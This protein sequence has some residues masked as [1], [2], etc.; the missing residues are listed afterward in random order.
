[1]SLVGGTVGKV[2]AV[3]LAG[4]VVSA[5]GVG[6]AL[7]TG[8]VSLEPPTV[9]SVENE[10]GEVTDERTGIDTHVAVNNPNGV[11][12]PGVASVSYDVAMNDVT[13]ASG[14]S[15][16]LSLSPGTNEVTLQTHIDN[17]K[18]P[19]WWATHVNNGEQTTVSVQP[20]IDAAFV[21]KSLPSQDRT[22]ET[23]ILSSFNSDESRSMEVGGRTLLTV[24]QTRASW[25]EATEE[26][27]P[28][29]FSGT[30]S[31]PNDAPIVFSKIGYAVTMNDVT[32]AEGT[33]DE[34]VHIG[35]GAT[36]TIHVN[37]TFD[38]GKLDEWW[39][40]HLRNDENT[41]LDVQMF[42][43]VETD[44]G[45]QRVPLPFLSER[46]IFETD[47]LGGGEATTREAEADDAAFEPPTVESI[48]RDWRSTD[49][50]TQFSTQV[51]V[52][53]PNSADSTLGD[54]SLNASYR[55]AL[56]DVTL[57]EDSQQAELQ[58]GRNE[59]GFEGD[60]DD[61]TIQKWWISHVENGEKTTLTT[62]SRVYADLGFV[63]APVTLPGQNRTFETDMLSGFAETEQEVEVQGRTVA[64]LHDMESNWG[65]PT[66]ER[67]PMVV[68][69][70]VTN[71]RARELTIV[72][73]GY[74]VT[75]NDVVLADNETEVGTTIPGKSTRSIETTGYL[76]NGKIP[77]WWVSHLENGERSEL[78]VT[79]Y[80]IVEYDGNQY[81]VSLDSMSYNETIET[82]AFGAE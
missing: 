76:D 49:S 43:V 61:Q 35:A 58:P 27:T 15:G 33:T 3:V 20:S 13:V 29:R 74:E 54:V 44:D 77:A 5:A 24:E 31:N 14:S 50:G 60:V 75:M 59:L 62:E 12:I 80:A 66:M 57:L 32:V 41:T 19:A 70:D 71:E 52:D 6:A 82:N 16:G 8:V 56:N 9:E 30:V 28:L 81:K 34:G 21:S 48:E 37:S 78:S 7:S 72:K 1:M 40:S 51:V 46:V 45:T 18:I 11:G 65:E 39:V 53:N 67:T 38:N 55:V 36:E 68:T 17:E 22:F 73:F 25:G 63:E 26:E 42:A 64:T 23:D 4:L 79:Y 47:I 10:W 69:G 2:A